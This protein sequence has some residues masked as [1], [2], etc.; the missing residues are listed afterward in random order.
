M[1]SC[2]LDAKVKFIGKSFNSKITRERKWFEWEQGDLRMAGFHVS[3]LEDASFMMYNKGY[4]D[5]IDPAE[6]QT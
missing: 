4:A 6:N 1:I 2:W 3:Q 5:N